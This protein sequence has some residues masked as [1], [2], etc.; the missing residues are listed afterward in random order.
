MIP[1][2]EVNT[3]WMRGAEI[4]R[5]SSVIC[6]GLPTKSFESWIQRWSSGE[7]NSNWTTGWFWFAPVNATDVGFRL[8]PV[9]G[10]ASE[11]NAPASFGTLISRKAW[12]VAT[13]R[14][15]W[16]SETPGSSS[17]ILS[18]P[19]AWMTGSETPRALMRRSMTPR[20]CVFSSG[21]GT[22][23]APPGSLSGRSWSTSCVPPWRSSPRWVLISWE[24]PVALPGIRKQI[25]GQLNGNDETPC[26]GI[27]TQIASTAM[28]PTIQGQRRDISPPDTT[29]APFGA[30]H[31]QVYPFLT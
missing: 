13:S 24:K 26:L 4:S 23:V 29:R 17:R 16:R 25:P 18:S 22:V 11:T 3:C 1:P 6:T 31:A 28:S 9:S 20:A 21:S 5:P 15:C 19:S 14:A 7:L 30:L 10:G 2:P 8:A 12:R 27:S